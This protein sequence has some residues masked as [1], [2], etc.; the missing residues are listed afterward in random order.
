MCFGH[1]WALQEL[2]RIGLIRNGSVFQEI[3]CTQWQNMT[4][5]AAYLYGICL[6]N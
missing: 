1:G 2:F 6:Y 3:F 5:L 4:F